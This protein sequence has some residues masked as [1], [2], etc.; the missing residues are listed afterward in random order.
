MAIDHFPRVDEGD[1]KVLTELQ[2]VLDKNSHEEE[3]E[4]SAHP[5]GK[6]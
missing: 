1:G 3:L 5:E 2:V 6:A 4:E